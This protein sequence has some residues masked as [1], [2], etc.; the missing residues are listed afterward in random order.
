MPSTRFSS[1]T[2]LPAVT[3]SEPPPPTRSR[4]K[5]GRSRST[6]GMEKPRRRGSRILLR[7]REPLNASAGCQVRHSAPCF[8]L[9]VTLPHSTDCGLLSPAARQ[10]ARR[11]VR[12][13][14]LLRACT[15]VCH[16][17]VTH[18]PPPF[19]TPTPS[20]LFFYCE[21]RQRSPP[22]V[23]ANWQRA[24]SFFLFFYSYFFCSRSEMNFS[25]PREQQVTSSSFGLSHVH[26]SP[27]GCSQP[28]QSTVFNTI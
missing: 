3:D 1:P 28:L 18:V 2:L 24:T 17:R 14:H 22:S 12:L 27:P 10:S 21:Q 5:L 23:L 16:P 26:G 11:R 13:P 15:A 8:R 25:A 7:S 20:F 9:S 6:G 19:P 4:V